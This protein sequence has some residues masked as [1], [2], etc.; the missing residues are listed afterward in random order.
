M[1]NCFRTVGLCAL[2]A[3]LV[4]TLTPTLEAC[5]G[6]AST[7]SSGHSNAASCTGHSGGTYRSGVTNGPNIVPHVHTALDTLL[8]ISADAPA[9]KEVTLNG[10]IMC[11]KCSLK[12]TGKCQTAIVVNENGKD[13]PYIFL[14]KGASETYHENVC[15]GGKV[16][17]TV[18]GI[19]MEKDGKKWI[20]PS[21]VK[22]AK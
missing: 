13:V 2:V 8:L 9:A 12:L 16:P 18:T 22:Y 17:G 4:L 19:V 7:A 10:T 1:K 20:K 5:G 6:C 21:N 11:A 3:C 15:G 14:D